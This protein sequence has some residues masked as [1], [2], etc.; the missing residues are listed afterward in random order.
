MRAS[1]ILKANSQ[2]SLLGLIEEDGTPRKEAP[3]ILGTK[4][5]GAVPKKAG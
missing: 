2:I 4:A 5:G 3:D 1:G